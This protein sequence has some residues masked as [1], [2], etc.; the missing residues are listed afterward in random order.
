MSLLQLL[1]LLPALINAVEV[2]FKGFPGQ[3]TVKK[4]VVMKGI[5]GVVAVAGAA[6]VNTD[7]WS[8]IASQLVD[9]YVAVQNAIGTFTHETTPAGDR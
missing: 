7:G 9:D 6:G 3:G 1:G 8:R 2:L 4:D 5:D